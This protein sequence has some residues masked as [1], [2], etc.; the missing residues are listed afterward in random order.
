MGEH[1]SKYRTSTLK[2]AAVRISSDPLL[3]QAPDRMHICHRAPIA[4]PSSGLQSC[5]AWLLLRCLSAAQHLCDFQHRASDTDDRCATVEE[6]S[7]M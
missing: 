1:L 3:M 7:C 5:N 6:I 4:S 2:A